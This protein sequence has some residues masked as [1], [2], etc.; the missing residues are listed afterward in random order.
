MREGLAVFQ[1]IYSE[2]FSATYG[3]GYSEIYN[4]TAKKSPG[5]NKKHNFFGPINLHLHA[6]KKTLL[7]HNLYFENPIIYRNIAM[8]Q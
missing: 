2:I 7:P 3:L 1:L 8:K 6:S 4:K 5:P